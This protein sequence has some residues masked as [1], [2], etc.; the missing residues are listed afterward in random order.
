MSYHIRTLRGKAALEQHES[1]LKALAERFGQPGSMHGVLHYLRGAGRTSIPYLLLAEET[2]GSKFEKSSAESDIAKIRG[3][4]LVYEFRLFVLPSGLLVTEGKDGLRSLLAAPEDRFA[5]AAAF[6]IEI[7]RERATLAVL[8]FS[9]GDGH[10]S[11]LRR[12]LQIPGVRWA[13]AERSLPGYL[14]L[15]RTLEETLQTMGGKTRSNFR[16][17]RRRLENLTPL[18]FEPQAAPLM[19]LT[20]VLALNQRSLKPADVRSTELRFRTFT[21]SPDAFFCG[22]RSSTGDWLSLLGGWRQGRTA[23]LQWQLNVCGYEKY[24]LVTVA[25]SFWMED[26]IGRGTKILRFDGGTSHAMSHAF[27]EERMLDLVVHR[28]S[29]AGWLMVE[30][31]APLAQRLRQR[32][33]RTSFVLDALNR[34]DLVWQTAPCAEAGAPLGSSKTV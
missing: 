31:L 29:L 27:A 5:L 1:L 11:A 32:V 19:S 16:Y 10:P 25:R 3:V 14:R 26:E 21:T 12:T 18:V 28:R 7:L 23:V 34:P 13:V 30:V 4:L 15:G 22:L 20:E 33:P 8:S 24:S 2:D 6:A 17:Y 9:A